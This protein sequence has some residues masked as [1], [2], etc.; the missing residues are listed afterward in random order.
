MELI[1]EIPPQ[2]DDT[3]HGA[4]GLAMTPSFLDDDFLGIFIH[5]WHPVK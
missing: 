3:I 4:N 1:V 5:K 2:D